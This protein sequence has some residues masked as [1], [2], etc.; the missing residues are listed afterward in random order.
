MNRAFRSILAAA[1]LL[2]V[3]QACSDTADSVYRNGRVYTVDD[4]RPWAQ[5]LAVEGERLVFVGDDEG[6]ENI[7]APK[8]K[9][10]TSAGAW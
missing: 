4:S 5:A 7:S 10:S 8:R 3:I 6:V 9:L 1:I 2:P